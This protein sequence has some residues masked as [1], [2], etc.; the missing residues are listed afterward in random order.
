MELREGDTVCAKL[1]DTQR[2]QSEALDLFDGDSYGPF[3]WGTRNKAPE[4]QFFTIKGTI[5][6]IPTD[7]R[8]KVTVKFRLPNGGDGHG[9]ISP[10]SPNYWRP[11]QEIL[12]YI[13]RQSLRRQPFGRLVP[14]IP[15]PAP[16][17]VVATQEG[18]PLDSSDL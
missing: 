4:S 14:P 1:L 5:K 3:Y 16:D 9:S 13:G 10:D 12:F 17:V 15:A 2:N 11:P 18:T 8:K 7:G 6:T